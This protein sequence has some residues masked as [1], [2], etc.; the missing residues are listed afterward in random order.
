MLLYAHGLSIAESEFIYKTPE[1]IEE[2]LF[3]PENPDI[4]LSCIR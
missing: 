3:I 4:H 1:I 2:I